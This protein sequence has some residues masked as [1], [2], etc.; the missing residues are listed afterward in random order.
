M[1]LVN[2]PVPKDDH[3]FHSITRLSYRGAT[4]AAGEFVFCRL[5]SVTNLSRLSL[6]YYI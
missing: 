1:Q 5:R 2:L 4:Q 6:C 3:Q